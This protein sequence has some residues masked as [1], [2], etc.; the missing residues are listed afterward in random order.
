MIAE[1]ENLTVVTPKSTRNNRVNNPAFI[2]Y[3]ASN[4][5]VKRQEE[6]LQQDTLKL[7]KILMMDED[8]QIKSIDEIKADMK[9]NLQILARLQRELSE[10]NKDLKSVGTP[11]SVA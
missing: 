10:R 4:E 6:V 5:K 9:L 1:I 3:S 7:R 11:A 8:Q 2:F